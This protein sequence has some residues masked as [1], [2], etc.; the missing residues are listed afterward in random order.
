M[1]GVQRNLVFYSV[2][3]ECIYQYIKGQNCIILDSD[4]T[5]ITDLPHIR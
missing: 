1:A 5:E 3:R 2:V 4:L